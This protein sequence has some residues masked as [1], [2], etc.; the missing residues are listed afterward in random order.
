MGFELGIVGLPN[1][2][3]S[4][5][6]NALAGTAVPCSNYP[7]CTVDE[8][9]GVVPVP[10]ARL[11]RLGELLRPEKLTPTTIRFVDIAGLVRGASRGEGLGNKFLASIREVD[12]IA[13]VVRCFEAQD[14]SHVEGGV[15]PERD[16]GIVETEL[17]LAD[18]ETVERNLDKRK[19]EAGRGDREAAELVP[20]LEK[21]RDVLDAGTRVRDA[22]LSEAERRAVHGYRLLTAK[23]S[24]YVAN[25]SEDDVGVRE[26]EW[27][28]RLA[29][30]T[31][32]PAWKIVPM[33]ASLEMEFAGLGPDERSEFVKGWNLTETGLPRLVRAGYRLLSLVT[34]FTIKGAEV[35][36]WTVPD[37]TAVS[38]AAGR[39]HSDMEKG[40]IRADVVSFEHLV[41]DGSMHAA[42]ESGHVRTEG[43]GYVVQDGDVILVHF[44]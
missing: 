16:I 12:A 8:N 9:V 35:K 37:G 15:D 24:L 13:H 17:L 39:I 11:E 44:K 31:G 5:L 38:E 14:V 23:D 20:V 29:A 26:E 10:D 6:F 3:K 1:V 43:R 18:L 19:K 33:A 22:E 27:V 40:F 41:T 42:R 7:F 21:L 28:S 36:A 4:T 25:I 30:A 34:F 32:E 2:G